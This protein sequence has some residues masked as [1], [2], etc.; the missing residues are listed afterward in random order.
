MESTN[1]FVSGE[2]GYHTYRI[3]ALVVT[4]EGTL[5]AFCE[6]RRG[7]QGDAGDIDLLMKRSV[8]RGRTWSDH[9]VIRDDGQNT[10]GNPC[11]I[12][13]RETG[14]VHLLTTWNL[15]SDREGAIIKGTSKDT[16]RV[17][18][19]SSGDDGLTWAEPREITATVK[20]PDWTWYATGPG[21][22]IQIERGPHG[23][24]LVAPCDHIEADTKHY[25]SHVVISD[26]H[27]ATWRLA[28]RTPEH[29]VN[30]CE[31][32]ELSADRL[33]LNM[34]NYYAGKHHRQTAI[35]RDGG[36]TWG[37][38]RLD[39]TLIEPRCQA[40]L[41]AYGWTGERTREVLL[42]SNPA[43]ETA[44]LN[45]TVRISR[46][47]GATWPEA[48]VLHPGPSAYSDLVI[49]D[50]A[51]AAC[52]YEAGEKHPYERIVFSAFSPG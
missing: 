36:L 19:T 5:L 41:R 12:V 22:G 34:R 3:P 27:G 6:G 44:R 21:A 23:G 32:A 18:V 7:G 29:Q 46:D 24:R 20:K 45:M 9:R 42:F 39:P 43:H 13:D 15:G 2:A 31:V 49:F 38:Q 40:S 11:P 17:F 25:Y 8:D 1:V 50:R 37:E 26:D 4:G 10:C 14:R 16:R 30:E 33:M 47:E 52:L 51:H 28:G 35:S 48:R